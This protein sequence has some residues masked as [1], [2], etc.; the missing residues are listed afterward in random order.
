MSALS[1]RMANGAS[2]SDWL[3]TAALAARM[4]SRHIEEIRD[5]ATAPAAEVFDTI[6][7]YLRQATYEVGE[8]RAMIAP[9]S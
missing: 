8:V 2:V 1:T 7:E 3:G 9:R 4:A 5:D 6:L